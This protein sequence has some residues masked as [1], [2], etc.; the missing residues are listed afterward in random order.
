M[1]PEKAFIAVALLAGLAYVISQTGWLA[2]TG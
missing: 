1:T 2:V